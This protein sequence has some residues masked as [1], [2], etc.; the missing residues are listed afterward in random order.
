MVRN[1][2]TH[3][4]T[5]LWLVFDN[6][7]F[8]RGQEVRTIIEPWAVHNGILAAEDNNSFCVALEI[9]VGEEKDGVIRSLVADIQAISKVLESLPPQARP[10][11]VQEGNVE[12]AS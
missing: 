11:M 1:S 7:D 3:G 10:Q 12:I 4:T 2:K 6:G 9:P 8:G 5:P